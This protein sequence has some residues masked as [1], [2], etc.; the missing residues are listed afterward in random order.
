V[1]RRI[2]ER[3]EDTNEQ[4]VE[5]IR[6]KPSSVQIDD[7][8]DRAKDANLITYTKHAGEDKGAGIVQSVQCPTTD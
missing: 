3:E 5:K 1:Y 4:L 7:A 2:S 6:N 8:T